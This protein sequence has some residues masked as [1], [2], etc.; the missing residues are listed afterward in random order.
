MDRSEHLHVEAGCVPHLVSAVHPFRVHFQGHRLIA[1]AEYI[2]KADRLR[3]Q[4]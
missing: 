1:N 2:L 3:K 4:R